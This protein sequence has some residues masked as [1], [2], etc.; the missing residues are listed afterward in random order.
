MEMG[1]SNV[2]ENETLTEIRQRM[3]KAVVTFCQPMLMITMLSYF[4]QDERAVALTGIFGMAI[5]PDNQR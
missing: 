3:I 2:L 4:N 1:L 5:F